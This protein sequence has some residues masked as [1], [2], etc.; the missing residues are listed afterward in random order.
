MRASRSCCTPVARGIGPVRTHGGEQLLVKNA[1]PSARRTSSSTRAAS[2]AAPGSRRPAPPRR[3]V[4]TVEI[5]PL[6]ERNAGD[7]RQPRHERVPTMQLIGAIGD[8]DRARPAATADQVADQVE[9]R[10]IGPVEILEHD[11]ERPIAWHGAS[12]SVRTALN[13]RPAIRVRAPGRAP[14]REPTGE[15]G[16]DPR[17]VRADVSEWPASWRSSMPRINESTAAT[18][19]AYGS[20]VSTA[21][22]PPTATRDPLAIR[23][24]RQLLD[25][26]GLADAGLAAHDDDLGL[27]GRR[28]APR[29]P[30]ARCSSSSRPTIT[31][32]ESLRAMPPIIRIDHAGPVALSFG[33]PRPSVTQRP[34][35]SSPNGRARAFRSDR[36]A[37]EVTCRAGT[38]RLGQP[39]LGKVAMQVFDPLVCELESGPGAEAVHRRNPFVLVPSDRRPGR[40]NHCARAGSRASRTIGISAGELP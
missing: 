20:G 36:R 24:P 30:A 7:L 4:E 9:R 6:H 8:D 21:G 40:R 26:P 12:I 28:R 27:A 3:P 37:V 15:A 33:R 5:D 13:T 1:L 31:G 29:P 14:R 25:Q 22:Q 10:R 11:D 38:G 35:L 18:I 23:V 17:E 19:G 32:L 2:G 34:T 16:I 39:L